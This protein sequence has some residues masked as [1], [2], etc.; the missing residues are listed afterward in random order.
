MTEA[1][2][3]TARRLQFRE[4]KPS[5]KRL[6]D[7]ELNVPE[8][9]K[10]LGEDPKLFHWL[11]EEQQGP[12]GHTFWP[13]ELTETGE[14]VGICGLVTVDEQDSTV[15]DSLELGYRL[16][17]SAQGNGYAMEGAAAC[18]RHAFE[19]EQVWRVVSRTT[20]ENA[21]SWSV[22]KKIGMRHDP[23][24][25]YLSSH[26]VPFIVHV[27]TLDDWQGRGGATCREILRPA[28]HT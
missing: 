13:I 6:L 11:L 18:L 22:M 21:P 8:V 20:V 2:L 26:D 10:Y 14:F 7:R 19:Q 28:D 12:Y 23:R 15:V 16:K 1:P 17:P 9:I 4:L 27:M 24:L 5:D 25:D 3:P